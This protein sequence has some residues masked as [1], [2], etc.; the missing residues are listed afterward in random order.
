MTWGDVIIDA[1]KNY[2]KKRN[3]KAV[4]VVNILV[5]LEGITEERTFTFHLS[6]NGHGT[7]AACAGRHIRSDSYCRIYKKSGLR[8][9]AEEQNTVNYRHPKG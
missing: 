1:P 7:Q 3:A 2:P 8:V 6:R 9:R 5:Q 4:E